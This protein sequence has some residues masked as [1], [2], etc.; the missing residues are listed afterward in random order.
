MSEQGMMFPDATPADVRLEDKVAELERELG[1]RRGVYPR[2]IQ[3]GKISREHAHR[4]IITLE[5]ILA[6]YR[7]K[8]A[9]AL[10][11]TDREI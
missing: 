6:D 2:W 11:Q 1:V 5:A 8:L 7:G 10:A 4:R 3:S 9:E